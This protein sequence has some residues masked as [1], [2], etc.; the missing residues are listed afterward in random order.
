[1]RPSVRVRQVGEVAE[2]YNARS[3]LVREVEVVRGKMYFEIDCTPSFDWGRQSHTV[4]ILPYGALF[5]SNDM[6]LLLTSS[7]QRPWALTH[8]GLG[9]KTR[10]KLQEGQRVVFVLREWRESEEREAWEKARL[11]R[12]QAER[13]KRFM[14]EQIDK[15]W[16]EAHAA[17]TGGASAS[18]SASEDGPASTPGSDWGEPKERNRISGS[19]ISPMF[20]Q[21]SLSKADLRILTPSH[22]HTPK[23]TSSGTPAAR[24][25]KFSSKI[26][27]GV[28][29]FGIH[30][31]QPI[32]ARR[33]DRLHKNTMESVGFNGQHACA[34][35]KRRVV[36]VSACF[37]T[38]S[39]LVFD[40]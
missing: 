6:T 36:S 8:N 30:T 25:S 34:K 27:C 14:H 7:R 5:T 12:E 23:T 39:L 33:T 29:E 3:W 37:S 21:R 20:S 10:V 13:Q 35:C 9:V 18:A 4:T 11:K 19:Q 31:I 1:M 38:L 16:A 40:F 15:L 22:G 2:R 32:P 26:T 17:A 24:A 28:G